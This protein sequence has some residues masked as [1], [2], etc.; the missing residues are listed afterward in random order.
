[1]DGCNELDATDSE[2]SHYVATNAERTTLDATNGTTNDDAIY[3]TISL[4]LI[5]NFGGQAFPDSVAA[6]IKGHQARGG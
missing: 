5:E 2:P 6:K 4:S 3:M 1:L